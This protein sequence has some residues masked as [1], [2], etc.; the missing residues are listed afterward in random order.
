MTRMWRKSAGAESL[1]AVSQFEGEGEFCSVISCKVYIFHLSTQVSLG[2][3]KKQKYPTR[4]QRE[5]P[6]TL[7]VLLHRS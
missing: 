7:K 5:R 1:L 6:P 3:S 2:Q 4:G